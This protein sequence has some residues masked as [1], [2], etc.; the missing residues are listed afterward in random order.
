M[1]II[2]VY[3]FFRQIFTITMFL[4]PTGSERH[5]PPNLPVVRA[6]DVRDPRPHLRLAPDRRTPHIP[7]TP[8]EP[9]GQNCG[10]YN[11]HDRRPAP[12]VG[13]EV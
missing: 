5:S 9:V 3:F 2:N 6:G 4:H 1:F 13:C 7:Q 11:E 10:R 8:P 12:A